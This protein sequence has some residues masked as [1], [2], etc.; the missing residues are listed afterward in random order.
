MCKNFLG[1]V[2]FR[3]SLMDPLP[4]ETWSAHVIRAIDRHDLDA[5]YPLIHSEIADKRRIERLPRL[6]YQAFRERSATPEL[7]RQIYEAVKEN[8]VALERLLLYVLSGSE[9]L[10]DR[11][12]NEH[13]FELA[14]VLFDTFS[15]EIGEEFDLCEAIHEIVYAGEYTV[16]ELN[17]E[18]LEF[19]CTL[20]I[21]KDNLIDITVDTLYRILEDKDIEL[22]ETTGQLTRDGVRIH[23]S[24][25]MLVDWL[26]AAGWT[27]HDA[28]S[29]EETDFRMRYNQ[30]PIQSLMSFIDDKIQPYIPDGVYLE[31]SMH[32]KKLYESN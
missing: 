31:L 7:F 29:Q 18:A 20:P 11:A 6:Y 5:L 28:G 8:P 4:T 21:G 9:P 24:W 30:N 10:W 3:R 19:L 27:P 17:L 1:D 25:K 13:Y 32:M 22:D 12:L 23:S 15:E 2:T 16:S 26:V 14:Q